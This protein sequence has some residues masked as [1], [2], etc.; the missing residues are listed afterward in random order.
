MF[1]GLH[2]LVGGVELVPITVEQ[3]TQGRMHDPA[4]DDVVEELA[5]DSAR[6]FVSTVELEL[7]F[8]VVLAGAKRDGS[9]EPGRRDAVRRLPGAPSDAVP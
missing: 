8:V 7:A 1:S 9:L 6:R 4:A 3:R 2:L 5:G